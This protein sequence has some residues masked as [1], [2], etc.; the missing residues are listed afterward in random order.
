MATLQPLLL[1]SV[2][3]ASLIGAAAADGPASAALR[4]LPPPPP[5]QGSMLVRY[6]RTSLRCGSSEMVPV[7][8]VTPLSSVWYPGQI[9]ITVD[10]VLRF[11]IDADGRALGIVRDSGP[12]WQGG[13]DDLA[14]SLAVTRFAKGAPHQEC[15]VTYR[16][17][18]IPVTQAPIAALAEYWA[19]PHPEAVLDRQVYR[20]LVPAGSDCER[21]RPPP[22]V[23]RFPVFARIPQRPGTLSAV[24][25][26]YDLDSRG[27]TR[28]VTPLAPSGNPALDRAATA[29]IAQSRYQA[30]PRT[31]CLFRFYQTAKQPTP[32]P[33][34]PDATSFASADCKDLPKWKSMPPLVF[35]SAF[36]RRSV[37]GWAIIGFDVALW[38]ATGKLKVLAS[39]PAA[40]FGDAAKD[41]VAQ[42]TLPESKLGQS[43]CAEI[44]QFQIRPGG[45]PP[46]EPPM[47]IIS[48][49]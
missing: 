6:V 26:R 24:A 11:R 5:N 46:P 10:Q 44:V 7:D 33:P 12:A 18:E 4:S 29:A 16:R 8:D 23:Q 43:G 20:G 17:E 31:G 25:L 22:E 49:D 27:R 9:N 14:P 45:P 38:G 42:A 35:P 36:N 32:A 41:I 34:A 48:V 28:G 21:D 2:G 40:A 15:A 30:G 13:I 19:T 47:P 39:E 37:E 1:I 3:A